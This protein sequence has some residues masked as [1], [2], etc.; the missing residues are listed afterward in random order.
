MPLDDIDGDLDEGVGPPNPPLPTGLVGDL[1]AG[2]AEKQGAH[3]VKARRICHAGTFEPVLQ[4]RQRTFRNRHR[5]RGGME[6]GDAVLEEQLVPG[7]V[8]HAEVDEMPA[9]LP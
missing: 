3:Q 5:L 6:A 7:W 8:A 1:L 4:E 2:D 9:A